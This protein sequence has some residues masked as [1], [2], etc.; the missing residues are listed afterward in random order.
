MSPDPAKRQWTHG[1]A[2]ARAA[3]RRAPPPSRA[4]AGG[5]EH[6]PRRPTS[7]RP[8]AG[9]SEPGR[10]D[11]AHVGRGA[12]DPDPTL[13][14]TG[15]TPDSRAD[16]APGRREGLSRGLPVPRRWVDRAPARPAGARPGTTEDPARLL[17]C[18]R[19]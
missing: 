6:R 3:A 8:E 15:R 2:G 1:F 17:D 19:L 4:P 11:S 10:Y 7:P 14:P 12:D 18:D 16:R 13:D 5:R 9:T